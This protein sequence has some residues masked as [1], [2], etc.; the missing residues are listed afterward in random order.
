[1]REKRTG[2]PQDH[3]YNRFVKF[4]LR[5]IWPVYGFV[6]P[7]LSWPHTDVGQSHLLRIL[8][9]VIFILIGGVL[10]FHVFGLPSRANLIRRHPVPFA[11]LAY[12]LWTLIS[13]AFSKQPTISLIGD[14][15][16]MNDG[17]LWTLCLCILLCL[18]YA[19]TRRDPSQEIPVVTAVIASG[20][21]LS[22]LGTVEV[23]TGKS[24]VFQVLDGTLPVVTFPGPGHLG[25]FLVLSGAL[26]V[27]WWLR[28]KQT[29]MWVLLIVFMTSFG[30]TLTN[31]RTTLIALGASVL[32][33]LN[34]PIRMILVAAV[35]VGGILGGQQLVNQ[36]TTQGVRA[37][38]NT[39]TAKTRSFLWKAALGGIAARPITGWGGS[40]FQYEWYRYLTRPELAKYMRLE[41]GLS[42]GK[43]TDIYDTPG[44]DRW[45]IYRDIK[46][47]RKSLTVS[48][49]KAHNQFLDVLVM[50]GG[51]GLALYMLIA[52]MTLRNYYLPGVVALTSYQVFALIWYVP[53]EV[54]GVMF[55]LVGFTTAMGYRPT[56]VRELNA[57]PAPA[58][59]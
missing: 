32:A 39:D 53:L 34:Q 49:W 14:L 55:L 26:A 45:I 21:V 16:Y 36:L 48:W 42:I 44:G 46:G 38:T 24:L 20:L 47:Q 22:V 50:W 31:R 10:E 5:W 57:N 17:A 4:I 8:V 43:V 30:M 41:F 25:G 6:F 7:L 35:L 54:E 12:G 3:A 27:G 37:F 40:N 58:R 2:S 56:H 29:P 33:G 59:I 13:S 9:T 19:R 18:V 15:Q 23:V 51:V 52:S 28:S 11:A 1:M